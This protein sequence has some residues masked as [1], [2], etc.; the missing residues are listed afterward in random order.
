MERAEVV[1]DLLRRSSLT[2]PDLLAADIAA[3]LQ[4]FGGHHLV[5]Y[6]VDYEQETL[7][8]VSLGSDLLAEAP[9]GVR[10]ESTMAGRAFQ[11]QEVLT[12]PVDDGWR[13]WVPVRER[14][15]RLGVLEL[16]F[17]SIDDEL[18]TLTA[19]LGLLVAHL[20]HSA[21]RYTDAIEL[22]R[23]L[24]PMNLAAEMQWDMLLP[25]LGFT[26]PEL[27]IAGLLEPA[28]LVAGDAFDFSLNGDI[29]DFAILDAMGHGVNSTLASTLAL[30]AFRFARRRHLDLTVMAE[31]ID[32][33]LVERFAN[34]EFVT[35]QL[36][37]LDV[38]TGHFRWVNAGHPLPFL[39]RG[40]QI[41]A[42]MACDPCLPFGLG[43]DITEVGEC[44]LQPGDQLLF[45]S[46]G[47]TEAHARGGAQF[48]VDNL[49]NAVEQYIGAGLLAPEL[50]RRLARD[51]RSHRGSE[52]ADDATLVF[53]QWLPGR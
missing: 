13:V 11:T 23:R 31:L 39:I 41:V 50:L 52:L 51:L 37:Q 28:Y 29:L 24:R 36:A 44:H 14:A 10:V 3:A 26:S 21:G 53:L 35:G 46:D 42:E 6:V 12:A 30:G 8:P 4:G 15:E 25:P 48:G 17:S 16:G 9:K 2:P 32:D 38:A 20:I 47:V 49:R 40:H 22:R 27:S 33:A 45:Y 19:D 5:L 18:L 34:D 1:S 43:I 7:Q